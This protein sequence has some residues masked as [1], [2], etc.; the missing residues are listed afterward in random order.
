MD[1]ADTPHFGILESG[2]RNLA[3]SSTKNW[4]LLNTNSGTYCYLQT[5]RHAALPARKPVRSIPSKITRQWHRCDSVDRPPN[6]TGFSHH[7]C[8][9]K[10][11]RL[12]HPS[13][14]VGS[15][16]AA[17]VVERWWTS[18]LSGSLSA[19]W[20]LLELL[21]HRRWG[22]GC[23]DVVSASPSLKPRPAKHTAVVVP[24]VVVRVVGG[25]S[26]VHCG[27][28]S[29]TPT[30]TKTFPWGKSRTQIMKVA[31]S[32]GDKLWNFTKFWWKS[33]TQITKVANIN[34]ISMSRCLQQSPRQTRLCLS[35]GIWSVTMHG[36]SRRLSRTQITKVRNTNHES[37]RHDLCRGLSWFVSMT[38]P[39][40]K[41]W[42]KSQSRCNGIWAYQSHSLQDTLLLV[43]VIVL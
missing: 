33:P 21:F 8:C 2:L 36:E 5:N 32:N 20:M 22:M 16:S 7:R 38:F 26:Q 11:S 27:P 41:F 29:I 15:T 1:L 12:V 34:H 10:L 9:C 14:A 40:G 30:F 37:R 28:N 3:K 17:D 42:W 6:P 24:V 23:P 19:V 13:V 35:N 25:I 18:S 39:A 4:A 31:D 43:T